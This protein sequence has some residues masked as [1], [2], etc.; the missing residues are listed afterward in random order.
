MISKVL[1]SGL[2]CEVRCSSTVSASDRPSQCFASN[3]YMQRIEWVGPSGSFVRVPICWQME[4]HSDT[5]DSTFSRMDICKTR[6]IKIGG[7]VR[8]R[9]GERERRR[10]GD[11]VFLSPCPGC[12]KCLWLHGDEQRQTSAG[13][14][15]SSPAQPGLSLSPG[16]EGAGGRRKEGGSSSFGGVVL[17]PFLLWGCGL[18]TGL[19]VYTL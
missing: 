18:E 13:M 11:R 10:E 16:G 8:G 19:H 7:S 3:S 2:V 9:E 1:G 15:S 14:S 4:R 12:W 6:N 17:D 5:C